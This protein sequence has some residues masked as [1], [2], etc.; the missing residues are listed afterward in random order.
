VPDPTKDGLSNVALSKIAVA[1]RQELLEGVVDRV[2]ALLKS[3]NIN[4]LV[5]F[6]LKTFFLG[7][8]LKK[9]LQL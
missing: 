5:R 9:I 2:D 6:P 3:R 7:P 4:W 8:E 1:A